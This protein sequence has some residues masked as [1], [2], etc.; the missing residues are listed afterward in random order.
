MAEKE[1]IVTKEENKAAEQPAVEKKKV[2]K[3]L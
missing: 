2:T 3:L 1:E